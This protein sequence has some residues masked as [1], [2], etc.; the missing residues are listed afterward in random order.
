MQ[1]ENLKLNE[2]L[3]QAQKNVEQLMGYLEIA[4]TAMENTEIETFGNRNR[5]R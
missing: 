4:D 1:G 3:R 5:R 2:E